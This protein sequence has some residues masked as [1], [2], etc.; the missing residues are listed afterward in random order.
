MLSSVSCQV[1]RK[2]SQQLSLTTHCWMVKPTTSLT[3][4]YINNYLQLPTF[5]STSRRLILL[6]PMESLTLQ[7]LPMAMLYRVQLHRLI[8]PVKFVSLNLA[9]Y[10]TLAQ[11]SLSTSDWWE[12]PS[13]PPVKELAYSYIIRAVQTKP[14]A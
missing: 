6:Y 9:L 11:M 7:Q 13:I 5:K 12:I 10:S 1:H 3:I 4:L 14:K 2:Q 8:V